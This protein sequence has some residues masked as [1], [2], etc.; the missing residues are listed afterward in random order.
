[1]CNAFYLTVGNGHKANFWTSSWLQGSSPASLFP[2]L[3]KDSR[4]KN[5]SVAQALND[6]RWIKDIAY[7]LNE[8]VLGEYFQLW[9]RLNESGIDLNTEDEDEITW[10]LT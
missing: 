1:M 4:R 2:T 10:T 8:G 9:Q 6:D 3:Y 5:R 7:S